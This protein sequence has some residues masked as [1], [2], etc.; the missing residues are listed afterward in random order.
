MCVAGSGA[1]AHAQPIPQPGDDAESFILRWNA[2][3][4][5]TDPDQSAI[6]S[7]QASVDAAKDAMRAIPSKHGENAARWAIEDPFYHP[8]NW[9]LAV[10]AASAIAPHC[11]RVRARLA[12]PTIATRFGAPE[13][14]VVF[15]PDDRRPTSYA[16]V[17]Q[18]AEFDGP[19]T[20]H[21]RSGLH[22]RS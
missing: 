11:D 16:E 20:G 2:W 4:E 9:D 21:R 19:Q 17:M 7:L 18:F 6:T 1:L 15:E 8:D 3:A 14:G 13:Q 5:A 22:T 10:K 12:A